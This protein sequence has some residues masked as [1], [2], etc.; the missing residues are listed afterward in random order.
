MKFDL[1]I[2][3]PPYNTVDKDGDPATGSVNKNFYLK[4]VNK[5]L[6]LSNNKV[7]MIGPI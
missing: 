4:F 7:I 3:N 2:G 5:A 6:Q 1:V